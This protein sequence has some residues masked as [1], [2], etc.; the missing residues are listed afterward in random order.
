MAQF[1]GGWLDLESAKPQSISDKTAFWAVDDGSNVDQGVVKRV[2]NYNSPTGGSWVATP[3]SIN[4][5]PEVY[6]VNNATFL[7]ELMKAD[8]MNQHTKMANLASDLA[9]PLQNL[10]YLYGNPDGM[11]NYQITMDL[12]F[13][14][15]GI[16]LV[17]F[18]V[19]E[20][21]GTG[22]DQHGKI[23][24]FEITP[25]TNYSGV[26]TLQLIFSGHFGPLNIGIRTEN[27]SSQSAIFEL[28]SIII[29]VV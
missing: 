8:A 14:G 29:P 17:Q 2:T 9:I 27:T 15:T 10:V 1:Q 6:A 21:A 18:S 5:E 25:G 4:A 3:I 23:E 11:Y 13:G 16:N 26:N 7:N 28:R 20:N 19:M 12:D 22:G 24:V